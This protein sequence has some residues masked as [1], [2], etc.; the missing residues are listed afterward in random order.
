[1]PVSRSPSRILDLT[2]A[3]LVAVGVAATAGYF[4]HRV[5]LYDEGGLL[6]NA[7]LLNQGALHYRD[8]YSS[9]APGISVLIIAAWKFLGVSVTS[10]R[11]LGFVLHLLLIAGAGR[12]TGLASGLRFSWLGAGLV[13]LWSSA[14][15]VVPSAWLAALAVAFWFA[16]ALAT[17]LERQSRGYALFTGV[18]LGIV[19]LFRHDLFVYVTFALSGALLVSAV[20][21]RGDH[22]DGLVIRSAAWVLVGVV[23]VAGPAW[24][25]LF[26]EAG[27]GRVAGDL[28]FEQVRYVQP[29]RDLPILWPGLAPR[30]LWGTTLAIALLAP[31]L[32]VALTVDAA[33]QGSPTA[34]GAILLGFL[35]L[36]VIPQLTGRSEWAHLLQSVA[37]G[38]CLL[39]VLIERAMRSGARRAR[40]VA[41]LALVLTILIARPFT[42]GIGWFRLSA[43]ERGRVESGMPAWQYHSSRKAVDFIRQNS[44]PGEPIFVGNLQHRRVTSNDLSLYYLAGR[45]AATRWMQFDP[46]LTTREDVQRDIVRELDHA[47]P[48][49]VVLLRGGWVEEPNPSSLPGSSV[50]DQYIAR[51]YQ[52]VDSSGLHIMLIRGSAVP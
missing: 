48:R 38:L 6:T 41:A 28:L 39:A 52:P 2:G 32:A 17:W 18:L 3:L 10:A 14:L 25:Y 23:F 7:F 19:S 50:L 34:P 43:L 27:V 24:L 16:S 15:G 8:F 21:R 30:P 51:H 26:A 22:A 47:R 1:M 46:G 40:A 12:L 44:A 4:G 20:V 9:Y 11:V 45:P 36:A 5:S 29:A 49:V 13:A 31:F 42:V 37:P 33:G 35:T